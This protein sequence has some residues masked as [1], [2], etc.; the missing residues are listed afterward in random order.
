[1]ADDK[2]KAAKPDKGDADSE[3]LAD[4]LKR[5]DAADDRE[6]ENTIRAYED[7]AFKAGEQWP[8]E[9]RTQR[10]A[11]G[12][13]CL[14]INM[15]P[16]YVRQVTGDMRLSKPSIKVVAV[17]DRGDKETADVLAGLT[18][19]IENRSDA[20]AIYTTAAD[21]QVSCGVG[22]WRVTTEYAEASTFNQEIRIIGVEDSPSVR[23]DPDAV[24]P[25]REDAK[26]YFVPVDLTR[27]AYE[28]RW[29][30]KP[31]EDWGHY[32]STTYSAWVTDDTIRVVEYWYKKPAKRMLALLPNGSIDDLTD[33]ADPKAKI[34]QMKAAGARIEERESY[35]VCRAVITAGCVLEGP[36]DWIGRY[37]PIV[38]IFG[39]E[40]RVGR[41]LIRNGIVRNCMDAQ[42]MFNYASSTQAEVVALQPKA[43][44]IG[45]EKN[46]KRFLPQWQAANQKPFPYLMYDPDA[47]N[48]NI[49]PQRSQPAVSSTGLSELMDRARMDMQATIG[50]YDAGLGKRS[51][52]TSG[53]AIEARSRESDVGTFVYTA[54]WIRGISFT[55]RILLDLIPHIYDTERVVRIIGE[56]GKE[57]TVQINKTHMVDTTP[58]GAAIEQIENDVTIGAYDVVMTTGPSFTTRREEAREGMTAFLQS[59]GE[60]GSVII[61]LIAKAQDW[62][63]AEEIGERLELILPPTIQ[64]Q[65]RE[66]RGEPPPEQPGPDPAQ[67]QAMQ[68]E[69]QKLQA[70]AQKSQFELQGKQIDLQMKQIDLELKKVTAVQAV[71]QPQGQDAK[72]TTPAQSEQPAPAGPDPQIL[73]A[74]HTIG[75]QLAANVQA[76]QQQQAQIDQIMGVLAQL[77]P[78]PAAPTGAPVPPQ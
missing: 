7:L 45:T 54:N 67:Q 32:D 56:D 12:R 46:F 78:P 18:R 41:K 26:F 31:V 37:I 9:A 76:D 22:Y 21:S 64:A 49:V 11:E 8:P 44:F 14:T 73:E 10:E 52:E 16:Q 72:P 69:Q 33:E 1:M 55:G 29:P 36:E 28:E 66:K 71:T 75:Q 51:N 5:W 25:T 47:T 43:P 17:D 34:A 2:A 63:M 19:Y 53:K 4:A 30:D 27:A 48:N 65:I 62:P 77:A 74:L 13:P 20:D 42:R 38:P 24:L 23:C 40:T 59:A 61:D 15:V 70:D 68:A 60:A 58:E 57:D 50:I 6:H 3:L 39:E 35:K